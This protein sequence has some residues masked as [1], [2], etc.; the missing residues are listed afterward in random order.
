MAVTLFFFIAQLNGHS[1]TKRKCNRQQGRSLLGISWA[2]LGHIWPYRVWLTKENKL[3][4]KFKAPCASSPTSL[5]SCVDPRVR[6]GPQLELS[7]RPVVLNPP[8]SLGWTLQRAG[9]TFSQRG[10]LTRSSS[11]RCGREGSAALNS[12]CC[13]RDLNATWKDNGM[14]FVPGPL[15]SYQPAAWPAATAVGN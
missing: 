7:S 9:G 8:M 1:T 4:L 14:P 6:G 3:L 13:L 12:R 11:P 15:S 5:P 2:F 10:V